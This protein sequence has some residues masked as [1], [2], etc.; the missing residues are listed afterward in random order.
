[1]IREVMDRAARVI[2]RMKIPGGPSREEILRAAWPA[3]VGKAVARR[4]R[5]RELRGNTLCVEVEDEC[6]QRQLACLE[7]QILKN[8]RNLIGSDQPERILFRVCPPRRGPA[9][10]ESTRASDEADLIADPVLR[11]LYLRQRA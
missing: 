5:V 4:T 9:S 8:L 6:W 7:S 2:A 10:A 11:Q 3:A 1:M